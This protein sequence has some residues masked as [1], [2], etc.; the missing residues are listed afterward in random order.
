MS[1]LLS[2]IKQLAEGTCAQKRRSWRSLVLDGGVW[3]ACKDSLEE[4]EA[5]AAL[6]VVYEL[7]LRRWDRIP[8]RESGEPAEIDE[9]VRQIGSLVACATVVAGARSECVSP[10]M[11]LRW[12]TRAA[13]AE[14]HLPYLSPL[15]AYYEANAENRIRS[16]FRMLVQQ[17]PECANSL[18]GAQDATLSLL[19]GI[20]GEEKRPSDLQMRIPL[21]LARGNEG[22]LAWLWL[23]RVRGGFGQ[24]IQAPS[25]LFEPILPDLKQALE[26]AWNL[27]RDSQPADEDLRWWLSD[28]PTH[29]SGHHSGRSLPIGGN[30]IAAAA[31]AGMLLLLR[32]RGYDPHC[33]ISAVI[34]PDRELGSVEGFA[35]AA[36]KLEAAR[37][38]RTADGPA[39]VVVSRKN[40]LSA[41]ATTRWAAR[42]VRVVVAPT[43]DD[44][45]ALA[46]QKTPPVATRSHSD[47]LP[48]FRETGAL[49]LLYARRAQPDEGVAAKLALAL[50]RQGFT[51]NIDGS[52]ELSVAW[53]RATEQ[54]IRASD[55]VLFLLSP[56]A[57]QS[58]MLAYELQLAH[59]AGE[60]A[61][62][63]R[64]LA[65]TLGAAPPLPGPLAGILSGVEAYPWSDTGDG[66][67]LASKLA[68]VLRRRPSEGRLQ[69][70][71]PP[72]GGLTLGSPV[73]I[74]RSSDHLFH[75]ALKRGDSIIR[76]KG[77]RQMGKTSL[78]SRGLQHAREQEVVTVVTDFQQLNS[79]HLDSIDS[80]LR[81]LG[82]WLLR[83]V[84]LDLSL[85]D[86]WD[87]LQGASWNLRD[88]ILAVLARISQPLV[89]CMDEVDRL[90]T[91][92][93]RN[94]V[95]GLF[96]SWHNDRALN[97][98]L[99]WHRLTLAMSYAT[100]AHLFLADLNQSPFNVGT[101]VSLQDFSPDEVADL[102]ARYG[103]PLQT[104][105]ELAEYCDLL[106]GHPFLTHRGLYEMAATG[107]SLP[108][109]CRSAGH[110]DGPFGDH[111]RRLLMLLARDTD[112]STTVQAMLAGRAAPS[113]DHYTRL[114]S[115]GVIAGNSAGA[116]RMRCRL[117]ALYLGRYLQ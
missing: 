95:F 96:R 31:A 100:E 44:A 49:T 59:E 26:Q 83:Q 105:G 3:Q 50:R 38:L 108:D 48:P 87:S 79:V 19:W 2:L 81:T 85:D 73:Y 101:R 98:S 94:E 110:E 13:A 71:A 43:L 82:A 109:L 64:L 68:A 63:P 32:G 18:A 22:F 8:L 107:I 62:R 37:G 112:L 34:G 76:I 61:G 1:S 99:P 104:A 56:A 46:A 10:D 65:V 28:L 29:H 4:P 97:P 30:S 89:W 42:G 57:V 53:A 52:Q 17:L 9:R 12:A 93:F 74:E 72:L 6:T 84:P 36:P 92:A 80:L 116:A 24:F 35:R 33:A 69:L 58:E 117:Y 41:P 102:N 14:R 114:W 77:A 55:A 16:S 39:R 60:E 54:Q 15:P 88:L 113:P 20:V 115:G 40:Q 91:C 23:E 106:G 51:V 21:L 66:S 90:F 5:P 70:S 25:T 78:L 75:T 86:C 11:L 45:I 47:A 111:L 67:E 7:L 103:A 27:A